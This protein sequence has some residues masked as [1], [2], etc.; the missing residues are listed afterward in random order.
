M[1]WRRIFTGLATVLTTGAFFYGLSS[2]SAAGAPVHDGLYGKTGFGPGYSAVSLTVSANGT[3]VVG[4][5]HGVFVHCT[6][7]ASLIAQDTNEL[8]SSST[9]YIYLPSS[10]PISAGGVF[11][12]SGNVTLSPEATQTTMSFTEPFSLSGHFTKGTV[13]RNKTVAVIATLNA[14]DICS[15]ITPSRWSLK[16]LGALK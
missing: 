12:Y 9:L 5:I 2:A 16:W 8:D 6:A 11:S 15:P 10:I 14:P 1:K 7:S 4:G 13:I 3:R